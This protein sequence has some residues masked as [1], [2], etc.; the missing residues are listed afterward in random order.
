MEMLGENLLL[1]DTYVNTLAQALSEASSIAN[2]PGLLKQIIGNEM[3]KKRYC[4]QIRQDVKFER[5]GDFVAAHPPEGLG[6]NMQTLMAICKHSGD[7]EALDALAKM[8]AGKQ[9]ER[10]D[11]VDIVHEVSERPSGNSAAAAMRRLA[12][13]VPALHAQVIAGELS[14]HAAAIEAGFRKRKFQ[15]PDDPQAAGRYLAQ[16]VDR[17]WFDTLIDSYYKSIDG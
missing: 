12:K 1:N 17:A 2:V 15:L 4:K 7:M 5:F 9:G 13:D 10:N 6:T 16:R 8:S 14:P 3:W 11:L